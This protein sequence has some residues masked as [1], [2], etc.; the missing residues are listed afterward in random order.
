MQGTSQEGTSVTLGLVHRTRRVAA[1]ATD[2]MLGRGGTQ[3]HTHSSAPTFLH[4]LSGVV[5]IT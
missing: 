3:R 2:G 1:R 4:H 5:T